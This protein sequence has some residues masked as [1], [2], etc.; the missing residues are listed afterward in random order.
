MGCEELSLLVMA[1]RLRRQPSAVCYLQ[2]ICSNAPPP[3]P[4][5]P[6]PCEQED[7]CPTPEMHVLAV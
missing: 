7:N 3:P 1:C 5:P 6:S 2:R 4:P